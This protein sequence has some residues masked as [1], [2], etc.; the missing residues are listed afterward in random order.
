MVKRHFG[1]MEGP[2]AVGSSGGRVDV[3]IARGAATTGPVDLRPAVRG[4]S[5]PG[6]PRFSR[7]CSGVRW[8]K[9]PAPSRRAAAGTIGHRRH[10]SE[11]PA[12]QPRLP[13]TPGSHPTH[14]FCGRAANRRS[15]VL[16]GRALVV[17][18]IFAARLFRCRSPW[19]LCPQTPEVYRFMARWHEAGLPGRLLRPSR[20]GCEA[21]PAS[22]RRH[23]ADISCPLQPPWP[24]CAVW[25]QSAKPRGLGQ[26]PS[27]ARL[28]RT[29]RA[30]PRGC[31]VSAIVQEQKPWQGGRAV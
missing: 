20:S 30:E 16:R 17:L 8:R 10:A 22:A 25:H 27:R 31:P 2:V 11:N 19:G 14:T 26:S 6:P 28:C 24:T 15:G 5:P 23:A 13:L 7:H 3:G 4:A 9:R 21:V 29:T 18:H 12:A 1:G